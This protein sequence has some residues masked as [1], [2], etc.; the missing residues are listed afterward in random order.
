MKRKFFLLA[1]IVLSLQGCET[2]YRAPAPTAVDTAKI[3][4]AAS[5]PTQHV[6]VTAYESENCEIGK[7][8][9][10]MGV[11]GG[12]GGR[13]PAD[14][15]SAGNTLGMMGYSEASG[16]KP[17]ERVIPAGKPF[18]FSIFRISTLG[19]RLSRC[20]LS[21]SFL[22]AVGREYEATFVEDEDTCY[23]GVFQLERA[24]SGRVTKIKEPSLKETEKS[25]THDAAI[26]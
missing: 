19:T 4:F 21:L 10:I 3:R 25:C 5:G 8:G 12:I 7:S 17:L 9:G 13:V 16:I 20:E 24:P 14:I 18:A 23:V 11:V 2:Y 15:G 1:C 22:P 6:M 26:M